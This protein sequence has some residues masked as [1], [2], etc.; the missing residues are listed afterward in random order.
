MPEHVHQLGRAL[1]GL[2]HVVTVITTEFPGH[3]D[4]PSETPFE[5]VRLGR[6]SPPLIA[7]GSLSLAAVGLGLRR[8]LQRLLATRQFDVIHVHAPIFPTLALLAIACAPPSALLIGTL[9]THFVDSSVLRFFRRPLQRYLDALDGVIAVSETAL[10]S[11]RRIG[12]RCEAEI[13]PNGVDLDGWQRGQRLSSLRG[14]AELVLL[15]QARLE[16]RNRI[17]TVIAALWL[18]QRDGQR[19]RFHILGDGPRRGE[20][21]QQ[22]HGLDCRFAGSVVAARADYAASADVFCFTAD[23]ASHPMSLIEGMAAG[24]PVLAH[25]IAGVRELIVDGKEGLLV[26]LGDEHRYAEA[27]RRLLES[28]PLRQELGAAAQRRVQPLAWPKI[29][30]R[31]E[32]TYRALQRTRQRRGFSASQP[33]LWG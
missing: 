11:L 29:A 21:E 2:G 26:P 22:A 20:L 30:A 3:V 33:A 31:I 1:C 17:E 14:G 32:A 8:R 18:L 9:H 13:I 4:L 28:A 23:I 6:A 24:L 12:F 27:L 19:P 5:I 16:P 25:P 7:N 15:A 10:A